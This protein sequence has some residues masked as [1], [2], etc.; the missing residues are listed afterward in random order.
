M[1]ALK[2]LVPI[3]NTSSEDEYNKDRVAMVMVA[4]PIQIGRK[5]PNLLPRIDA[6]IIPRIA[7]NVL[8]PRIAPVVLADIPEAT[9]RRSKYVQIPLLNRQCRNNAPN[10]KP[11]IK[12]K[13]RSNCNQD[14]SAIF[15]SC[16]I[17]F[18][19]NGSNPHANRLIRPIPQKAPSIPANSQTYGNNANPIPPTRKADPQ[20]IA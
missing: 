15:F 9:P 13:A 5:Y 18:G 8:E 14:F 19:K 17:F 4:V 2:R 16:E 3:A 11:D 6:A 7:A 1:L 10:T 20:R 12:I